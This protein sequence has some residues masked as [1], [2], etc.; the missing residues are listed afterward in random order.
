MTSRGP[1]GS[2]FAPLM[3]E[4]AEALAS[5][6]GLRLV[7]QRPGL[8]AYVRDVWRHR[9]LMWALAKGDFVSTHQDNYLGLL[10]SVINP[11]L[12]GVSYYLI[13]GILIGT[14]GGVENF[15]AFLTIGLFTY[16]PLAAAL[17]SGSKSVLSK[18]TMIRSLRFPRV[19]LPITTVLSEFVASIPAFLTLLVIALAS[20][21]QPSLT[22]LLFAPALLVV[23]VVSLGLAMLTARVV[24][25][26]RDAY[27]LVPLVVRLLR[28]VSGV[29]FSVE[30]SLAR[31]G[32]PPTW[33]ASTLQYQPV[34][35]LLTLVREPLMTEYEVRWETWAVA[36]G[37]A[38]GLL[39]L[40][41]V[42]FWR[43]E[44]SYGRA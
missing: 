4:E 11:I 14:R 33:I 39:L 37:W 29:F 34:A 7:G 23:L 27:N 41:F 43:G 12:L 42:V 35:V 36:G 6:Y 3:P 44:G 32:D 5:R 1:G 40:G 15:V 10:W 25:A 16:I 28:Y 21:E 20:G 9:H 22:W 17:T 2:P 31:L 13:F 19:L 18:S 30:A 38:V 24:H 8:I 26:V